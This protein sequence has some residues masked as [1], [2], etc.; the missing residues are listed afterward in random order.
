MT[1]S[2]TNGSKKK[3][4]AQIL[5]HRLDNLIR[6]DNRIDDK[7]LKDLPQELKEK[8]QKLKKELKEYKAIN[9]IPNF[10]LEGNVLNDKEILKIIIEAS[11]NLKWKLDG[12]IK[13][14][15]E[16]IAEIKEKFGVSFEEHEINEYRFSYNTRHRDD[17][18][19]ITIISLPGYIKMGISTVRYGETIEKLMTVEEMKEYLEKEL[20]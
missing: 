10:E 20:N 9:I 18:S 16:E 7:Y 1:I 14:E 2:K 5:W 11:K 19:M 8:F 17:I 4:A 6:D 12:I 3:D 15:E 13:L